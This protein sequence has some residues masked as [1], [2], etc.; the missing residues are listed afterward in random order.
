MRFG[1]HSETSYTLE[2]QDNDKEPPSTTTMI[3]SADLWKN[4]SNT[5]GSSSPNLNPNPNP[6]SVT[7]THR[8]TTQTSVHP[9]TAAGD[10]GLSENTMHSAVCEQNM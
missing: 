9:A 3:F 7:L 10:T 2:T 6:F 5:R 8:R 1:A 4:S